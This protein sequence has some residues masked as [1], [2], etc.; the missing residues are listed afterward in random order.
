MGET[1][2]ITGNI[3]TDPVQRRT[4]AGEPVTGF[5]VASGQRRLD[6]ATGTWVDA[7]TNWYAVSVFR[8]LGEHALQS[9]RKGDRVVL[10]GRLR[11]REWD[12]GTRTGTSIEIDVDA[13]GHDLLWGTT[14]FTKSTRPS[15]ST[16]AA[17]ETAWEP[18]ES[19]GTPAPQEWGAPALDGAPQ[20]E[21]PLV[22]AD[23]TPF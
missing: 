13:I 17:E 23:V 8:G 9:L 18:T 14:I 7:D 6:R 19:T 16:S 21:R 15:V 2:T 1:I 10:T 12:N 22:G 5:R 20:S 11:V 3:A 4:S